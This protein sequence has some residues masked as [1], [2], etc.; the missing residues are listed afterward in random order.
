MKASSLSAALTDLRDGKL[1]H[2]GPKVEGLSP[3]EKRAVSREARRMLAEVVKRKSLTSSH[4]WLVTTLQ[5]LAPPDAGDVLTAALKQ[6][7]NM[8][9]CCGCTENRLIRAVGA[10]TPPQAIPAL[11][12][13]VSHERN[14]VH[15]NLAAAC[16]KKMVR[17]RGPEAAAPLHNERARLRRALDRLEKEVASTRPVKPARPW[18]VVPGSPK[19][20]AAAQRAAKAITHLLERAGA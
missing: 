5:F 13:V 18:N 11:V 14:P 6:S 9:N 2:I 12:E 15:K 19:W 7:I 16:M 10:I 8:K 4:R 3:T 20:F 17:G 1:R